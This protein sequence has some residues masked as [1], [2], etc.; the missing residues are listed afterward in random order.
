MRFNRLVVPFDYGHALG[1]GVESLENN[2]RRR[3]GARFVADVW[4]SFTADQQEVVWGHLEAALT[5][6][7]NGLPM[8]GR[9][10]ETIRIPRPSLAAQT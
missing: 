9:I 5:N 6:V 4:H 7:L 8:D 3:V 10:G 2:V 1:V